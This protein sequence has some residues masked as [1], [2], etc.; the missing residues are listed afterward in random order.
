ML[1]ISATPIVKLPYRNKLRIGQCVRVDAIKLDSK[2]QS[3]V[4]LR[5]VGVWKRGMWFDADYFYG[6]VDEK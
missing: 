6:F 1:I 2:S 4:S 3:G 5:V